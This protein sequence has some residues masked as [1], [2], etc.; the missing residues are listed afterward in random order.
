[1]NKLTIHPLTQDDIPACARLMADTPLWVRYG[2]TLA[3]AQARLESGLAAGATI[4]VAD[5]DGPVAGFVWCI[6]RGAFARSGYISLI[7]VRPGLTGGG[8][9]A[10]LLAYAETFLGCTSPDVFLTVSDFNQ[11]AQ[12][13]Y[14]K[15][16]YAQ[17]GALPDYVIGGVAELVYWKRLGV[18]NPTG[19]A[20]GDPEHPAGHP[21]KD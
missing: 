3:S 14:Q 1:M 19:S 9:G 10:G 16:G 17:V 13:F 20:A 6:E 2:V 21:P 8:V 5:Y 11:D 4:F 18:S 12:R 7:G 15:H